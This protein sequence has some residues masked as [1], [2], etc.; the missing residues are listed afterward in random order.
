MRVLIRTLLATSCAVISVA[1]CIGAVTQEAERNSPSEVPGFEVASVRPS[2]PG[3]RYAL[4]FLPDGSLSARWTT[5]ERLIVTAFSLHP[6]QV[7]DKPEWVDTERFDIEAKAPAG[8][9]ASRAEMLLRLRRLLADRFGL[10]TRDAKRKLD[11]YVLTFARTNKRLGPGIH[12]STTECNTARQ[13]AP[14]PPPGVLR[15]RCGVSFGGRGL[16]TVAVYTGMTISQILPGFSQ[17]VGRMIVDGTNLQGQYDVEISY[18]LDDPPGTEAASFF[19]SIREQLGLRLVSQR[20]DVPAL[21]IERVQR[22]GSN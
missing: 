13:L 17:V 6:E 21:V 14:S 19:T 20:A 18:D 1:V 10:R 15:G 9:P 4:R 16:G 11:V 22:P 8:A 3:G 5:V 2:A 7:V 12:P